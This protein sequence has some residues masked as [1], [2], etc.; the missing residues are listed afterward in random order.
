MSLIKDKANA[1]SNKEVGDWS[2]ADSNAVIE[3][4]KEWEQDLEELNNEKIKAEGRLEQAESALAAQGFA[5]L[6]AAKEELDARVA[7]RNALLSEA[8]NLMMTYKETYKDFI[9]V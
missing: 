3:A 5:T 6:Q 2:V 9:E 1:L 8:H 4:M 7:R